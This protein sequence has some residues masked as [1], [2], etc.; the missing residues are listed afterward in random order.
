ML[1]ELPCA[2]P[3]PC[4]PVPLPCILQ[5][6]FSTLFPP[7]IVAHFTL[8]HSPQ[9]VFSRPL[10]QQSAG[11]P[12]L[13]LSLRPC[14]PGRVFVDHYAN[15]ALKLLLPAVEDGIFDDNWRIRQ[16]SALLLGKLLFKVR[17]DSWGGGRVGKGGG[18]GEIGWQ[19]QGAG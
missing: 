14:P 17:S 9:A 11:L 15:T 13:P 16:S 6:M 4:V 1:H 2:P 19:L 5:T 7:L 12:S 10:Y 3:A 8:R 18:R